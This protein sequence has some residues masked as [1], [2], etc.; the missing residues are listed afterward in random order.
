MIKQK[1]YLA[2]GL[3]IVGIL[4]IAG[5]KGSETRKKIDSTVD[6][7]TGYNMMRQGE[8]AKQDVRDINKKQEE[9]FKDFGKQE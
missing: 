5:C 9:R 7:F 8:K 6:D 4:I 1:L 3:L 2:V